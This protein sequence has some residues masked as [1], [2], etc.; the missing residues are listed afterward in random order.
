MLSLRSYSWHMIFTTYWFVAF[1]VCV[2]PVYWLIPNAKV[3][4]FFL[5]AACAVFH[6][7]FAGPAGV[8]PILVLMGVTYVAGL[9]R[10]KTIC[11]IAMAVCV[12]A[13]CFYKY[14]LFLIGSLIEPWN[15]AWAMSVTSSVTELMP[16]VPPLGVSFF[17]FEFVHYLYDV[18]KGG[19]P[20][21]NPLKFVLFSIFFPSLVA[22]PI[23]RY[24][25]FI[26]A[27]EEGSKKIVWQNFSEGFQR[28]GLGFLK[29]VVI[30]DN[31]TAY[32][33]HNHSQF[34]S[35]GIFGKWVIVAAIAFRI[36]MDFSGYSDIAIG[37]ARLLGV[38]LPENFNWPYA[39]RNVQDFWQRWHISLSS[40]IR[41]YIYIPLGGSR[42]GVARKVLN[43]MIAFGLCGLW[44]GPAWNFVVWGLYH[45]VGL[46]LCAT[47]R[48]V[49]V[50]GNTLD[51]IFTKEPAAAWILTQVFVWVGWLLFFYPL[52]EAWTMIKGC[53]GL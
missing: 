39:A 19:A 4:L 44:H 53:F 34:S 17:V 7:H 27:L 43:G 47:Y 28:I 49:P 24:E 29:K 18:R 12:L 22:G 42:H 26:P 31:L 9:T 32:I 23:K 2:V 15:E 50:L 41:D 3:R 25:Q 48:Q 37:F 35:M 11:G 10:L 8:L 1:A 6:T 21:R 14:S 52:P 5:A 16:S 38:R 45:G 30:A 20:I 51:R 40:W 33:E 36:L 46:G 13:L